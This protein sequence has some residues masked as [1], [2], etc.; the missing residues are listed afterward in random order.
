MLGF[1]GNDSEMDRNDILVSPP[2]SDHENDGYHS[3]E[4]YPF[5]EFHEHDMESLVLTL[6]MKFPSDDPLREAVCKVNILKGKNKKLKKNFRHKI[7]LIC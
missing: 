5:S 4:T 3:P 7:I 6:G 1:T 2:V